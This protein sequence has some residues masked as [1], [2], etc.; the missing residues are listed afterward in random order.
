MQDALAGLLYE[1]G[2]E[3]LA[4]VLPLL[5]KADTG[6]QAGAEQA[7]EEGAHKPVHQ[8]IVEPLARAAARVFSTRVKDSKLR[9][10]LATCCIPA[11]GP[12]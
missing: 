4:L 2:R 7:P 10:P 5:G 6:T 8:D 3:I 1:R 12:P 11:T 9:R